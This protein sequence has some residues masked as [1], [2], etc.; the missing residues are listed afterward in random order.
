MAKRG[1]ILKIFGA[2]QWL[3]NEGKIV[4]RALIDRE[5]PAIARVAAL[6]LILYVVSPIDIVPD[7]IPFLGWV[8]DLIMIPIGM[9]IIRL[10]VPPHVWLRAGGKPTGRRRRTR[11]F[12]KD[13]SPRKFGL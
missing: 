5:T 11:D 12:M 13:I 7:F 4:W 9:A 1:G 2:W 8:D 3:K 6:G 10:L